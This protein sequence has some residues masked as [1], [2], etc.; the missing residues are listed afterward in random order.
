MSNLPGPGRVLGLLNSIIG[1][2]L[3]RWICVLADKNGF[4][5]NATARRIEGIVTNCAGCPSSRKK[6]RLKNKLRKTC[7]KLV[8]FLQCVPFKLFVQ[9][10]T[11]IQSGHRS[12]E[13]S[14]QIQA[15]QHICDPSKRHRLVHEV[16][17]EISAP[18]TLEMLPIHVRAR[19]KYHFY[20]K[21]QL[22]LIF[23]ALGTAL[24]TLHC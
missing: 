5:P 9:T 23:I 11:D 15:L 22:R 3:E 10:A 16:L 13:A 8:R 4:G 7:K 12:R 20:D 19:Q 2:Y 14:T 24:Q 18:T 1:R 21:E 17:W 6:S